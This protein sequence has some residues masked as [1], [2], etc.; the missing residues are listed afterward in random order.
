MVT[1]EFLFVNLLFQYNFYTN[2]PAK[3]VHYMKRV[4]LRHIYQILHFMKKKINNKA[5]VRKKTETSCY[6]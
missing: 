6:N 5:K 2:S 4:F 3:L 1:I